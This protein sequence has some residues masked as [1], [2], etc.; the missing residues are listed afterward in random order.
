MPTR[1][2]PL[3][4]GPTRIGRL[5]RSGLALLMLAIM[6]LTAACQL[7]NQLSNSFSNR[8]VTP[9]ERLKAAA[10]RMDDVK[11][12]EF[13]GRGTVDLALDDGTAS[14]KTD[15]AAEGELVFPGGSV[16]PPTWK[17]PYRRSPKLSG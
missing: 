5:T 7:S 6:S 14:L 17:T 10:E 3:I 15:L 4:V 12:A 1:L 9:D 16:P 13:T 2:I 8:E 11:T